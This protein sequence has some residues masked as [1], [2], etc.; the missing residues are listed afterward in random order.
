[1]GLLIA[2]NPNMQMKKTTLIKDRGV[3]METPSLSASLLVGIDETLDVVTLVAAPP[4]V[5]GTV[6]LHE[7]YGRKVFGQIEQTDKG[8]VFRRP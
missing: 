2:Q 4:Q 7:K 6:V 1:M 8:L 3:V 5:D